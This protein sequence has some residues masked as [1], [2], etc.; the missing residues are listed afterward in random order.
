MKIW[1]SSVAAVAV[2]PLLFAAYTLPGIIASSQ[3]IYGIGFV[4]LSVV[5]V[6]AAAVLILGIPTFMML[7]KYQRDS[8]FSLSLAG[9]VLGA[10]PVSFSWPR[11]YDGY[12]A[13]KNWHG[14]YVKTYIDGMPTKYAWFSYG[15]N[16]ML[17]GLHGLVG[18][19]VFYAV[20]RKL[21]RPNNRLQ[22]DAAS[23]RA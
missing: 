19:L 7:R 11:G 22:S 20:W 14:T 16:V 21:E 1:I 6:A 18:A 13:G 3:A 15:E 12:S 9:F 2:Q 23:P 5:V 17:F 10:L 4:L 8:W